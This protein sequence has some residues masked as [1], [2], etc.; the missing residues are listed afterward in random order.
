MLTLIGREIHD[1][2]AYVV[3]LC[4][5]SAMIIAILVCTSIWDTQEVVFVSS[6]ALL[7]LLL[8]GFYAFGAGQMYSDR[9]NRVSSLLATRAATRGRIFAARVL[10]GVLTILLTLIPGM[11]VAIAVLWAFAVPLEFFR[12]VIAEISLTIVL[13]ALACYSGGLVAG[14]TVNKARLMGGGL[15]LSL[16]VA[17]LVWIKG[18]GV[19]A[20]LLL[21]VIVAALLWRT[22]RTFT[23]ASL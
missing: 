7:A 11:V 2:L 6:G 22:W 5:I 17:S 10:V 15:F 13:T 12:R 4:L 1:N 20:A 16:L 3:G 9:A 14:W 18:F 21:L 8:F 19:G 23:S